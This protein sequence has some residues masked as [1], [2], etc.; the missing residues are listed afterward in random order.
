MKHILKYLGGSH[1]YGLNTPASDEDIR[2]IF[3]HTDMSFIVGLNRFE[4]Q[5][6]I[7]GGADE[8]FKELRHFLCLLR[9]ANSE[10]IEALFIKRENCL[11][12]TE[13]MSHIRANRKS[14]LDSERLFKCLMGYMQGELKLANGERT[15]KLGGK[16]KE[17]IDKYGFSPKNFV[18]LLRLA[19]AGVCFF[20]KGYFPV[21]VMDEDKA[22]GATLLDIKVNAQ[23]YNKDILNKLAAAYEANLKDAF[24]TRKFDY[25]FD[26]SIAN[27]L[28]MDLYGSAVCEAYANL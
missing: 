12:L 19:W 26:E 8:K 9:R 1:S 6:N 10:A 24:D 20:Q 17:Q 5:E 3:M 25:K 4:H 15:G 18:Q 21:N 23:N 7:A 16:R 22:L 28:C 13:E 11:E 2:G 27:T 14:L